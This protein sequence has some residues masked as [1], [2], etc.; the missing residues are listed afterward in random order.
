MDGGK[1]HDMGSSGD[2]G[3]AIRSLPTGR[4]TAIEADRRSARENKPGPLT[5]KGSDAI[6]FA[7]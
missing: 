1:P 3:H 4:P 2:D 5:G 7:L 6:Q